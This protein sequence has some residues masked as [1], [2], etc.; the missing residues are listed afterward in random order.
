MKKILIAASLALVLPVLSAPAVAADAA[1][2]AASKSCLACHAMDK[3]LMG[4]AFKEVAKKYAG[5]AGAEAKLIDKVIK[6]GGG[7]WG[8]IPMP[9]NKVTP[10]EAKTLVQWVLA[11]K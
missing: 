5:A 2:L 10:E 3:K 6:G 8:P 7:V 9:A 1:A 4:P 11:Q